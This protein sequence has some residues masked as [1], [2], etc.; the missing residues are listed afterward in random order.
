MKRIIFFLILC[1]FVI[2]PFNINFASA[3]GKVSIYVT[4]HNPGVGLGDDSNVSYM[5]GMSLDPD[6]Q[7]N[8]F[9]C[10]STSDN[11]CHSMDSWSIYSLLPV[12]SNG[13]FA[14]CI[15][16]L[17][18]FSGNEFVKA[19]YAE[20]ASPLAFGEDSSLHTPAGSS[21][22]LWF[23]TD[24]S[25]VKHFYS[26]KTQITYLAQKNSSP[27]PI[28][29][30]ALIY[31]VEVMQAPGAP[32][33]VQEV[34]QNGHTGVNGIGG[35]TNPMDCVYYSAVGK[36][37]IPLNTAF[38]A[39]LHLRVDNRLTGW[40]SGRLSHSTI[41]VL[42]FDDFTN[43]LDV[44][45]SSVQVPQILKTFDRSQLPPSMQNV[46]AG[47]G[48][49]IPSG[50]ITLMVLPNQLRGLQVYETYKDLLG[51]RATS[52]SNSWSL[53]SLPASSNSCLMNRSSLSG[54]VSTNSSFYSPTPPDYQ[55]GK[56]KYQLASLHS[57]ADGSIFEGSYDLNLS[58]AAAK[59][60]YGLSGKKVQATISIV[61]PDGTSSVTTDVMELSADWLHVNISGFT[62]SSPEVDL[63]FT[64]VAEPAPSNTPLVIDASP[65]PIPLP[66]KPPQTAHNS[67]NQPVT[68]IPSAS[69]L[70][71]NVAI[72]CRKGKIVKRVFGDKC[73]TGYTLF[74][75]G[76]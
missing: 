28:S 12:C 9:K 72:S 55:D 46:G 65:S 51:D 27:E 22:S 49:V 39:R 1:V 18:I 38:T 35:P 14:Q 16:G 61:H 62:F 68:Q 70:K 31:P 11:R 63:Q 33:S 30:N 47:I 73:P 13:T 17:D 71:R 8:Q 42:K 21:Q 60:L 64:N 34:T 74:R 25:L 75:K 19:E 10:T 67:S 45:G 24:K 29:M 4:E 5:Q 76:N 52:I 43:N 36:C 37:G 26:V 41:A 7:F 20:S 66:S 54:V 32:Y 53:R 40:L 44:T 58:S 50:D 59:C 3:A 48:G 6:G 23:I 57:L 2:T 69:P 56:L 15:S